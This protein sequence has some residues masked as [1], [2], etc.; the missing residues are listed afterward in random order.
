[1][2]NVVML[3]ANMKQDKHVSSRSED[4]NIA[5][6]IIGLQANLIISEYRQQNKPIKLRKLNSIQIG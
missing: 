6:I 3:S 2:E 4:T 5:N 1:M